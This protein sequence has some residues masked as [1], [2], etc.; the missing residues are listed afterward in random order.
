VRG[1]RPPT[2]GRCKT[3][4]QAFSLS[5]RRLEEALANR[6]DAPEARLE[7]E[8]LDAEFCQRAR[9]RPLADLD[10][11]VDRA[12]VVA[13][14][15]TDLGRLLEDRIGR[16]SKARQGWASSVENASGQGRWG[17]AGRDPRMSVLHLVPLPRLLKRISRRR[18][19]RLLEDRADLL[20]PVGRLPEAAL[21]GQERDGKRERVDGVRDRTERGRLLVPV[22]SSPGEQRDKGVC[23]TTKTSRVNTKRRQGTNDFEAFQ[24]AWI[25]SSF[26]LALSRAWASLPSYKGSRRVHQRTS[27]AGARRAVKI[28]WKHGRPRKRARR[29]A[30][31]RDEGPPSR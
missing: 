20:L 2:R 12:L 30:V 22:S 21:L 13:E 29:K 9:Q 8:L 27:L 15:A 7:P 11:D 4:G 6:S 19:I 10:K 28:G 23:Q 25:A 24:Y 3:V 31:T 16:P 18:Q 1:R 17:W 14:R 26:S 5:S